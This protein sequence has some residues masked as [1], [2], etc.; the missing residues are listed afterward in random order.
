M[1]IFIHNETNTEFSELQV[2]KFNPPFFSPKKSQ[3]A[4]IH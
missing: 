4:F 1:L 2:S 3:K